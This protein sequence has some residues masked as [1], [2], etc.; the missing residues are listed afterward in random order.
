MALCIW[1]DSFSV[2]ISSIDEQHQKLIQIINELHDAMLTGKSRTVVGDVLR[3]IL[4]Y[5][6]YHFSYEEKLLEKVH[7]SDLEHHKELHE[8]FVNKI[9]DFYN[10]YINGDILLSIEI[11]EFLLNWLTNHI[12]GTDTGY[13]DLMLQNGIT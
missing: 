5:T 13:T 3:K 12:K 4:E 11:L 2:K 9:A 6:Q 1:D 7:Y 10:K 8:A